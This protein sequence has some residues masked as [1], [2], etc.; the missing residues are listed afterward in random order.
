M[1]KLPA[2]KLLPFVSVTTLA[3]LLAACGTTPKAPVSEA[4]RA[5][6]Q[7]PVTVPVLP[8]K[9]PMPVLIRMSQVMRGFVSSR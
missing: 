1:K 5:T 7:P 3:A 4:P 9:Y 2:K 8:K 6:N